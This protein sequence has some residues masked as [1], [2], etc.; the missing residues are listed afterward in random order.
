MR[1]LHQQARWQ[2]L[3]SHRV[4]ILWVANARKIPNAVLDSVGQ[5]ERQPTAT[6]RDIG[7]RF[8]PPWSETTQG[9][10]YLVSYSDTISVSLNY[11][12]LRPVGVA[13]RQIALPPVTAKERDM[14]NNLGSVLIPARF[15]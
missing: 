1:Y 15:S 4:V 7:R 6:I 12:R 10:R 2:E 14:L 13:E 9:C 11:H 3:R 5:V 8:P